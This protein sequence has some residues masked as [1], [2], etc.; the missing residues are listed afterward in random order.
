MQ[1][2]LKRGEAKIAELEAQYDA[3]FAADQAKARIVRDKLQSERANLAMLQSRVADLVVRARTDGVFIVPQASDVPGRYVRQGEQLGYVIG[4]A[5]PLARVVVAQDAIDN[6]RLITDR[7]EVRLAE[8]PRVV[9]RGKVVREVPAGEA[10]LPSLALA[11]Q[12]GGAIATDPRDPKNPQ[13]LQRF[14][15]LDVELPGAGPIDR[16]GQRVFVR[17]DH[18]M[19]PLAEQWYRTIRLLFLTSFNV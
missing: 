6:V 9:L 2:Q 13:A 17:F 19:E 8:R 15:Q 4:K 3:E 18:R 7:V 12:E 14:F 1:A 10:M 16:Y 5:R 11:A